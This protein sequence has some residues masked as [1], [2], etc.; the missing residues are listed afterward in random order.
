VDLPPEEASRRLQRL[1]GEELL[2]PLE[3]SSGRVVWGPQ[4][5]LRANMLRTVR[6]GWAGAQDWRRVEVVSD[7][8]ALDK[9]GRRSIVA[10]EAR[11]SGRGE[12]A[13]G[14][15]AVVGGSVLG[16]VGLA[17]AGVAQLAGHAP[18]AAQLLVASGAVAASG[19]VVSAMA[20]SSSAKRWQKKIRKVR[21]ELE[22]VLERL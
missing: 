11:L 2:E 4:E 5:G 22:K 13:A 21:A 3:R 19:S 8:R 20:L 7:V 14:L 12:L 6:R 18:D 16:T 17:V 10:V 15:G 9:T 1:F